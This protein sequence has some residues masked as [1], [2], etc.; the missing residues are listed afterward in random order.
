MTRHRKSDP[1][2]RSDAAGEVMAACVPRLDLGHRVLVAGEAAP[3][4]REALQAAGCDASLWLR[5]ASSGGA[6]TAWPSL[7][8]GGGIGSGSFGAAL[9]R[10]PRAK[11]ELD[12]MLHAAAAQI[13]AGGMIAVYGAND[14]GIRSAAAR[15]E[16]LLGPAETVG[17]RAHCRVLVARRPADV[18]GLRSELVDWRVTQRIAIGGTERDWISYPGVFAKGGLDDGTRLLVGTLAQLP[19]PGRVLDYA[20]GTGMIAAHV[21]LQFPGARIDLADWDALAVLSAAENV[22]GAGTHIIASLSQLTDGPY[23]LIVS[24]PP[25]HDGKSEDYTILG[26]LIAQ[27]PARLTPKGH[28]VLVVQRRVPVAEW[29]AAAFEKV[30][31]IEENTRYIV[32]SASQPR[33]KTSTSVRSRR[34]HSNAVRGRA[35]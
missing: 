10:L 13:C 8:P 1:K 28:L 19:T 17:Q 6:V 25:I 33:N 22:P 26:Q 30:E 32:W 4:L 31:K 15:I 7:E 24:N 21:R 5:R 29:L 35:H 18:A 14:E 34:G 27:S 16:P 2:W 9:L 20:S 12:M 3:V 23:D 11:D